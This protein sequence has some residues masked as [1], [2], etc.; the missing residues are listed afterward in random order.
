MGNSI[1]V[2]QWPEEDVQTELSNPKLICF[3]LL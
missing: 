2:E 3:Q 1:Y